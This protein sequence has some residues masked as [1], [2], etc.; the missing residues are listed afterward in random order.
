M[1][2]S[3]TSRFH[4]Q[5]NLVISKE[6]GDR[7][8]IGSE[9]MRVKYIKKCWAFQITGHVNGLLLK[10]LVVQDIEVNGS[11][12]FKKRGGDRLRRQKD[13]VG[14]NLKILEK[15]QVYSC[16]TPTLCKHVYQK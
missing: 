5:S 6:V 11:R 7:N 2:V 10:T 3:C 14:F 16:Y 13:G 1:A 15:L 12:N 8:I 9:I 4:I